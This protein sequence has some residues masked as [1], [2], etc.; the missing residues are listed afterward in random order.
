MKRTVIG[1]VAGLAIWFGSA[2]AAEAQQI[3]PTGPACVVSGSLSTTYT[4]T[5]TLSNP[6][7]FYF[8]LTV[9]LNGQSIYYSQTF[10]PNPGTTTYYFSK[11]LPLI[12][13]PMSGDTLKFSPVLV[14]GGNTYT[15]SDWTVV[16]PPTRPPSKVTSVSGKTTLAMQAVER[17]RRRE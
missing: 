16:V 11:T 17:D 14:V 6:C 7:Y 15:G 5:V 8:R 4:A 12:P 10:V 2:L 13:I 1:A 9:Y 3:Q